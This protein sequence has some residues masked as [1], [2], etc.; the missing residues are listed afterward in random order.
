MVTGAGVDSPAVE[1]AVAVAGEGSDCT[2]AAD[3]FGIC[4]AGFEEA[5]EVAAMGCGRASAGKSTEFTTDG[6]SCNFT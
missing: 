6:S 3:G 4:P 1:D 2:L 5:A